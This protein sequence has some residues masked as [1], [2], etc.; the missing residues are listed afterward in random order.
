MQINKT[1]PKILL[2]TGLFFVIF[3]STIL[4]TPY[5]QQISYPGGQSTDS[6]TTITVLP[7][8]FFDDFQDLQFE[9][10]YFGGQKIHLP[11]IVNNVENVDIELKAEITQLSFSLR[12]PHEIKPE[13]V[14]A[15]EDK[16][17]LP[18]KKF[19][20]IE[21]PNVKRKTVFELHYQMTQE[22]QD[23][24]QGTGRVEIHV[25]PR[26]ILK[27]LQT[28]ADNIQLRINDREGVFAQVLEGNGIPFVDYRAGIPKT[29]DRHI[30]TIVVGSPG[31]HF[32]RD[33]QNHPNESIII[34]REEIT[35]IPNV[36]V[37]SYKTGMLID[38]YL[39]FVKRLADDPQCQK[40]LVDIIRLTNTLTK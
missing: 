11:L 26:D 27:P 32:L 4:S 1:L 15:L 24:W 36:M 29:K 37:Q 22:K 12:A 28:W 21:L 14:P 7:Q 30:V 23:N 38:V 33:K 2:L 39:K 19:I 25:Y 31:K 40:M 18:Y 13:I 6:L 17:K 34:L 16:K 3:V 5:A 20:S 9:H 10:H 8:Q 35:T